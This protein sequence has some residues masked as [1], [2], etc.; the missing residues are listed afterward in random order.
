MAEWFKEGLFQDSQ[1][2]MLLEPYSMC[3]GGELRGQKYSGRIRIGKIFFLGSESDSQFAIR[4][5]FVVP[6]GSWDKG[7]IREGKWRGFWG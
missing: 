4:E 3:G 1:D 5:A 6:F 2:S 7:G